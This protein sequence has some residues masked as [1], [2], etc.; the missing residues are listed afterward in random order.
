MKNIEHSADADPADADP[1][2]YFE[3][4]DSPHK[5]SN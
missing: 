2:D 5:S 4:T 1:A 3:L